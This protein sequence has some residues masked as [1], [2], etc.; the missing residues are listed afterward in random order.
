MRRRSTTGSRV[1]ALIAA[2]ATMTALAVPTGVAQA[3]PVVST[4]L[5]QHLAPIDVHGGY[6]AAGTG[7]RNRGDGSIH[8]TGVPTGASVARAY[9]YWMI[10]ANGAS[11]GASFPQGKVDGIPITGQLVGQSSPTCDGVQNAWAYRADVTAHVHG[12]GDY[13]LSSF[14]SA[15]KDGTDPVFN[16]QVPAVDGASLVVVYDTPSY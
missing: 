14:R 10:D 15:L 5:A 6:V 11:P 13:R 2:A 1:G 7:L 12:N 16:S 8:I 4:P 9:L 3:A